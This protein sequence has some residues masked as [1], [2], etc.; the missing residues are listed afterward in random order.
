MG[1]SRSILEKMIKDD[2]S[3]EVTFELRL[4]RWEEPATT[5]KSANDKTQRQKQVWHVGGH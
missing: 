2:L 5:G 4:D 3:E 1:S